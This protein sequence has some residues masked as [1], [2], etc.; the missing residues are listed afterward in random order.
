M[1]FTKYPEGQ[2]PPDIKS[3]G[4]MP[5]KRN[6][7]GIILVAIL[8]I[9]VCVLLYPSFS[10]YWNMRTQSR[11]VDN[12][13]QILEE[14]SED[15]YSELFADA[16]KYN[17]QISELKNPLWNYRDLSGYR[18][19]LD[20]SGTGIMGYITI[21]KLG[22]ELPI[23]HGTSADIL[24]NACGH[25]EGTSLPI[26]GPGTHSVLSAHRGLPHAKLFTDLNLLEEGDT[27]TIT[28]IDRTVT[29]LVD[30]IKVVKPDQTEDL[31]II[32]NEDY[33]TLLTCTPYGINSHRLLVRGTRIENAKPIL[34]V[35]SDAYIIDSIVATPAVAAPILL[36]LFVVLMVKY[37]NKG[38]KPII[39]KENS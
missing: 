4:E 29:Y 9:G 18:E 19:A 1:L 32:K 23:Y 11:A 35:T 15:Q 33:C 34:Y 31:E 37:R 30:Q 22:V 16:E 24:N 10:Q 3:N 21:D 27:F 2:N 6:K 8:L 38:S 20:P 14:I 7:T 17:D 5:M 13:K 26:G 28:I 25:L 12:Y 39:E 36:I